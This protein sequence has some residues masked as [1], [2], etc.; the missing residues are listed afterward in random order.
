MADNIT[1]VSTTDVNESPRI[2]EGKRPS[3]EI[4][5]KGLDWLNKEFKESL[6][7]N[8]DK[9]NRIKEGKKRLEIC[10][11]LSNLQYQLARY[12]FFVGQDE[13][14]A[15]NLGPKLEEAIFGNNKDS[16]ANCLGED[17]RDYVV[18][19]L[20]GAFSNLTLF[21]LISQV[22]NELPPDFDFST[23]IVG[24]EYD[25]KFKIDV[26]LDFGTAEKFDGKTR[27][28]KRIIQIKTGRQE[29]IIIE[30]VVDPD[31]PKNS[32]LGG[33]V[34]KRDIEMMNEG[35]RL[36]YPGC[37]CLFFVV[38]VPSLD[39]PAVGNIFG[40]INTRSRDLINNFKED[41]ERERLLP[42][43]YIKGIK[44]NGQRK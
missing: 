38:L 25:A 43:K 5:E 9:L 11:N 2:E 40:K 12:I 27:K 22:S 23:M 26:V 18:S 10:V 24:G 41:A 19:Q 3:L 36:L 16:I 35:A 32:Y 13:E 31:D 20:I 29:Q 28:I 8:L 34:T 44:K 15:K 1:E 14:I 21:D 7:R 30:R 6:R 33:S 17:K 4:L 42:K 39:S 37:V